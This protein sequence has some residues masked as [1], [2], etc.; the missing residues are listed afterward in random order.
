MRSPAV[1]LSSWWPRTTNPHAAPFLA[2]H[3]EAVASAL[4]DAVCWSVEPG[5]RPIEG[6]PVAGPLEIRRERPLVPWSLAFGRYGS[7]C[8]LAAGWARGRALTFRPA[9]LIIQ[10]FEHA[11]PY[12]VGLARATGAPLL[13]VEHSSSVALNQLSVGQERSVRRTL[14]SSDV[15]LAV[16]KSLARSL[17]SRRVTPEVPVLTIDNPLDLEL[18]PPCP[19]PSGREIVIAQIADFRLVKGHDLLI[20]ALRLLP[21]MT[22]SRLRLVLVGEG[23]ERDRI[24]G[25]VSAAGLARSVRFTGKLSRSGVAKVVREA[26]WT[27]LTSVSENQPCAAI[28]SLATGRPVVAA[29]VGGLS[30]VVQPEDGLLY[31]RNPESLA[32]ALARI[33]DDDVSGLRPWRTRAEAAAARYKKE[34]VADRYR[35]VI[36][37]IRV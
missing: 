12:G 32:Q 16:S 2:D 15:A 36:D 25:M 24:M 6:E 5:L 33:V 35:S 23:P 10:S 26:Q 9:A 1:V 30:E 8:L 14:S 18:F 3:A 7:E 19:P 34:A 13:Y 28:E 27:L 31:S 20:D 22:L 17:R 11:G 4:G 37:S 21:S 29:L